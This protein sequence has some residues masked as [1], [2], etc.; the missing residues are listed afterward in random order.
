MRLLYILRRAV[1]VQRGRELLLFVAA[2]GMDGVSAGTICF[3][4]KLTTGARRESKLI[5]G[6]RS[7]AGSTGAATAALSSFLSL[8]P[9]KSLRFEFHTLLG[10]LLFLPLKSWEP[11]PP[12]R[13]VR[14]NTCPRS[15]GC[16]KWMGWQCYAK[17]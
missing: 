15:E 7:M 6:Q 9:L 1:R 12:L 2:A 11:H 10:S 13:F 14:E 8:I 5:D 17:V 16:C 4:P 3:H